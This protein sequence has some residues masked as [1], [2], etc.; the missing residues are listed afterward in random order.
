M[1]LS[2][3]IPAKNE[4]VLLPQLLQAIQ[5]QQGV[6]IE[7]IVADAHSTDS[8]REKAS[9]LGAKIVDGGMPGPGRNMGAKHATG[10]WLCF[11][12]ADMLPLDNHFYERALKAFTEQGADF[13]TVRLVPDEKT[14]K[15]LFLHWLYHLNTKLTARF[16]PHIAG[17]CFFVK[18]AWHERT[19]GFD[20]T[21]VF[22]ED[23]EYAQR[24]KAQGAKFAY[25]DEPR[26]QISVRRLK[27]DGYARISGRF[28]YAEYYMRFH[29]PIRKDLFAYSFDHSK[30]TK[31]A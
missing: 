26:I 1:T 11:H 15:D 30:P 23:M 24:L 14:T 27:K 3:V 17:G 4:Q 22:A 8:T 6:Q 5:A 13:G 21:V 2:I 9:A 10:D 16:F 25:L 28:I 29:G 7:V 12:D 31:S 18:R 19:G 20:E